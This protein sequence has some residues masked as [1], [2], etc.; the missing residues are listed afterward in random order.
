MRRRVGSAWAKEQYWSH[1]FG[2]T[3]DSTNEEA[4][5][6]DQILSGGGHGHLILAGDPLMISKVRSTLPHHLAAK[7]MDI[8]SSS[9]EHMITNVVAV[10]LFSLIEYAS[11]ES[12]ST[13]DELGKEIDADGLAVAGAPACLKALKEGRADTLIMSP[14]YPPEP[15]WMCAACGHTDAGGPPPQRCPRCKDCEIL[16]VNIKEVIYRL[17]RKTGC[18]IELLADSDCLKRLGGI[19]CLLRYP[20]PEFLEFPIHEIRIGD[21]HRAEVRR[22]FPKQHEA[23]GIAVGER[24]QEHAVHDAERWLCWRQSRAPGQSLP[25]P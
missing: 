12:L 17:A 2:L 4:M 19:G 10:T 14:I 9:R 22:R 11:R 6:L 24:P 3:N 16:A 8:I 5:I 18:R 15:G 23:V 13:L 7:L 20:E 25:L 1:R 21:G